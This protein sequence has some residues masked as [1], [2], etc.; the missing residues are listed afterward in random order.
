MDPKTSNEV[1]PQFSRVA[2]NDHAGKLWIVII[3]SLIYSAF[4]I[5]ARVYIKYQMLGFDDL[6]FAFAT[7]RRLI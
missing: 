6:L 5:M 2:F 3:L 1:S 7:V 4:T